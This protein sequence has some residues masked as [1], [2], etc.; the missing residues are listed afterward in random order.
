MLFGE[1][2]SSWDISWSCIDKSLS[3]NKIIQSIVTE[4]G[5]SLVDIWF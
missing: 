1:S 5:A 2:E 3:E 4:E